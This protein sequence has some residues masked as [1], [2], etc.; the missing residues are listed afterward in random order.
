MCGSGSM[1]VKLRGLQLQAGEAGHYSM[2][3]SKPLQVSIRSIQ[4]HRHPPCPEHLANPG[5]PSCMLGAVVF[6]RVTEAK[7]PR[8]QR[9][10]KCCGEGRG[11]F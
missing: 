3:C 4:A 9:G 6:I 2:G 11:G 10:M 1:R 7:T 5:V 8:I